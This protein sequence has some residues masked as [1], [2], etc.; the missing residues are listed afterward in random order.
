[1]LVRRGFSERRHLA[2]SEPHIVLVGGD[3]WPS[4]VPRHITDI[5]KAL[6]GRVRVTVI[7]E[8]D[9]GGY[10]EVKELGA[11]HIAVQGLASHL[12]VSR[13]RKG[14]ARLASCLADLQADLIWAHAR[15]P[16]LFLRQL[17][18]SGE[19]KAGA[20][21]RVALSYHGLP[22]GKGHRPG[23]SIL[24]RRIERRLLAASGPL[25]LV[26]LTET[27]RA[28]M[29]AAMGDAMA[30]HDSHVLRNA[31]HLG[32]YAQVSIQK[33]EGRHLVMTGRTG[34]QKNYSAALRLM[35][36]LPK[37]ITL[38]LCGIGTDEPRFAAKVRRL[39]GPAAGRVRLC[40]PVPDVRPLLA[41]ADGY[42]LTSRYEGQPIGALEACE[43]G[44]PLILADFE[45]AQELTDPHPLALRL[46][47]TLLSQAN[48]VDAIL[49]RYLDARP[50]FESAIKNYWAERFT[51]AR[52]ARDTRALVDTLLRKV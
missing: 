15:L 52:F 20:G 8:A 12:N 25:D 29:L 38:S 18:A 35:R 43:Y 27:Q 21:T 14:R 28:G 51:P 47:G 3:G 22:F 24:A 48:A 42:M 40:G 23:T 50:T 4:G 10:R 49:N 1:M 17:Y 16:V 45:G 19:W 31:S 6:Q 11:K 2:L 7:S 26:F 37:D 44:L 9:K 13:L 41:A 46:T 36:H 39:A 33:P 5:V 30:G 34:Y 32:E